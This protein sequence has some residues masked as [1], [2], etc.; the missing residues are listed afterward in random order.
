MGLR[1]DESELVHN[2][3]KMPDDEVI[4]RIR[5]GMGLPES[6]FTNPDIPTL[7]LQVPRHKRKRP[8]NLVIILEESLGAEYVQ[9]LGGLPLTPELER[10][11]QKGLWF[12]Q[13]YATGTRSVRGIEAVVTGFPTNTGSKYSET[14]PFT[15]RFLLACR[16][17]QKARVYHTVH[18]RWG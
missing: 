18:L 11:S 4:H 16:P 9:S 13:L 7:H 5:K 12:S 8:L 3:G 15:E 1:D 10:L 2:Y 17:P 14:E 6:A